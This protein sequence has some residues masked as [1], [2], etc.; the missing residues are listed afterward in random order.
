MKTLF[1]IVAI[2]V[3]SFVAGSIL[4]WWSVAAVSFVVT[5]LAGLRPK[6]GFVAGF[7]GTGLCWLTVAFFRDMANDHI[8]STRMAAIFHLPYTPLF[9]I[10]SVFIGALIG[11]LFAWSAALIKSSFVTS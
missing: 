2:A 11:G 3:L 5:L 7:F 6:Q 10:V 9:L 4:P 1:N 8:L